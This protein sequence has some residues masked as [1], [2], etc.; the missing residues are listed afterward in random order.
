MVWRFIAWRH[1]IILSERALKERHL[2]IRSLQ[3][4]SKLR[5]N[6]SMSEKIYF[7]KVLVALWCY[8]IFSNHSKN[9]CNKL[10]I[11]FILSL[12]INNGIRR[13]T[14]YTAAVVAISRHVNITFIAPV[15]SPTIFHNPI[16]SS[17]RCC[18]I[19]NY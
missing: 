8:Y 9:V 16:I 15:F 3:N 17:I 18:A 19:P 12:G 14:S 4:K 7:I 2:K 5:K 10:N 11:V 13:F 6:L 1:C